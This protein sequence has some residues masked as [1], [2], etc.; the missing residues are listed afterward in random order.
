MSIPILIEVYDEM[1]R[2]AIAGSSVAPG[3]FRLKKLIAPLQKSGEKAPVFAKV[4]QAAQTVVDSNEKTA[5][6]ALL[7]LTTLVNAILY[8]QGETGVAG[9]YKALETIDLGTHSTQASARTLK[10]LLEALSTTGSGR[11]EVI[12]EAIERDAFKDLRLVKPALRAI[13]DPYPEISQLITE[14]V[15]PLYGKAILPELRATIDIKGRAGHL[16]RLQLLHKLDPQG[17][18]DLVQQTLADGSKEM[19]VAA[20]ECLGTSEDDLVYLLEQTKAKARD[21]RAAALR[22]LAMA[23]TSATGVIAALKKAIDSDDLEGIVA[24]MQ[25]CKMPEIQDYVLQ[26]SEAQWAL[27]LKC[28]DKKLQGEAISRL[29]RLVSC[30]EGRS[31]AKAESFLLNCLENANAMAGIKS[32][33]SGSDFN[34]LLAHVLARG[35]SKMQQRLA[36][37]HSTLS[38]EMLTSAIF[39]ARI[40]MTPSKFYNEFRPSLKFIEQKRPK[41]EAADRSTSLIRVLTSGGDSTIYRPWMGA[42]DLEYRAIKL[43]ELDPRW[44]D[45]AVEA[46][47]VELVCDLARPGHAATNRFLSEQLLKVKDQHDAHNVL[48]TMVRIGHPG[49]TDAVIESINKQIK[50]SSHYYFGYYY[51]NMIADLPRS[52]LPKLEELLPTLPD[53]C[54]D[55]LMDSVMALK[56]K[57]E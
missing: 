7:E 14:K 15:L 23:G 44:L 53:K 34:E 55:S 50:D 22:A 45:A 25:E 11:L 24:R 40:T 29:Q 20:I 46:G 57:P 10:P 18:R 12:R 30:L 48:R 17:S 52:A 54:V 5:A 3:D 35:T 43:T 38:G 32:E 8:T 42:V 51:A 28:K 27:T 56:N 39:A 4:A 19:K 41:K 36:S 16:L 13:D 21:V 37:S 33:P 1:R 26:Q 31:D 49:A 2:L 9:E 6:F 47:A